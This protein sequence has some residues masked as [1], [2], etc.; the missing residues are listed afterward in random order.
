MTRT[1]LLGVVVAL[2]LFAGPLHA[3]TPPIGTRGS[4]PGCPSCG[5]L[6]AIDYPATSSPSPTVLYGQL[7]IAGWGFECFAGAPIDRL[8]VRY[9]NDAGILVL[10]KTSFYPGLSRPDVQAAFAG[11][12]AT[13]W[14][15]GFHA[16]F[17]VPIPRGQREIYINTWSG[18]AYY[19]IHRRDVFIK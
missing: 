2:G 7:F 16:Y 14:D 11:S 8:E 3:A 10:A 6:S 12:C 15:S 1:T 5:V 9:R 17:D 18:S 13:R 4:F 19:E